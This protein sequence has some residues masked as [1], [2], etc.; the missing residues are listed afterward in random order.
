M[1]LQRATTMVF[2]KDWDVLKK[3]N[4]AENGNSCG[5]KLS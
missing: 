3:I 4:A 1:V 2:R 5:Y